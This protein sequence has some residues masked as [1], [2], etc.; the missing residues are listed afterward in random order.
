MG[1]YYYLNDDKTYRPGTLEEW[2]SQFERMDNHIAEDIIDGRH[3]STIWLGLDHNHFGGRPLVF[4]TMVF[5]KP[6]SGHDI[7]CQ[8]YSTYE[9]AMAGHQEAVNW[10]NAG[11]K[12]DSCD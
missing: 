9:E 5:D 7:Y 1:L 10:V 3:I 4:E 8:R 6:D 2:S 11:C 12:D